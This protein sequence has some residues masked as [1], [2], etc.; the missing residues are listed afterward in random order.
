MKIAIYF[1]CKTPRIIKISPVRL[2]NTLKVAQLV[3]NPVKPLKV[4][5]L[6]VTLS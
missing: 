4:A 2:V 3:V 6:V 1:L 5:Q